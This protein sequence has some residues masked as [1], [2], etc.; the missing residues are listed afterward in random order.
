MSHMS[1]RL[2]SSYAS[3]W[4]VS[5]VE[6]RSAE[7]VPNF[8]G[9]SVRACA[10]RQTFANSSGTRGPTLSTT[11]VVLPAADDLVQ[12]RADGIRP[13]RGRLG[14]E[15]GHAAQA[16]GRVREPRTAREVVVE[17]V[18]AVREDVEPGELLVADH[19][20]RRR[21]CAARGRRRRPAPSSRDA[22]GG[23]PCTSSAGATSPSRSSGEAGPSS[24]SAC[25]HD[26]F[27]SPV[28][29]GCAMQVNV[30][31][32]ASNGNG[33]RTAPESF[34]RAPH[35]SGSGLVRVRAPSARRAV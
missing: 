6:A 13:A 3:V 23:S 18:V 11:R 10:T 1:C 19:G 26:S 27:P 21:R 32:L 9:L 7:I 5:T 30:P 4:S 20:R 2:S 35:V 29:H 17:V 12:P 25:G 24:L 14:V 34:V 28:A 22:P 8:T 33:R 31:P 15:L 16:L